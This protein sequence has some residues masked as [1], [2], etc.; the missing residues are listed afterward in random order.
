MIENYLLK[1][2][3]I[4]TEKKNVGSETSL[5]LWGDIDKKVMDKYHK[6]VDFDGVKEKE[7]TPHTTLLYLPDVTG[8]EEDELYDI[9][10]PILKDVDADVFLDK[11]EVWEGVENGESDVLVV[12]LKVPKSL[13]NIR[14]KI[15]YKIK[16][17]GGKFKETYKGE[18]K[19]HATVAYFQRGKAPKDLKNLENTKYNIPEFKF[20]FGGR[21]AKRRSF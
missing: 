8:I 11:Y 16:E 13:E 7:T 20:Q 3:Q 17:A 18:W 9:I 10:K 2:N 6:P 4:F 14:E 19:A 21:T 1:L 12:R 5:Y 15:K